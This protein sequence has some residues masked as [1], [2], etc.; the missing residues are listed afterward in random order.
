MSNLRFALVGCGNIARKHAH[1]VHER[2][3]DAELAAFVDRDVRRA[4]RASAK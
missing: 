1:A 4:S 3:H 2:L